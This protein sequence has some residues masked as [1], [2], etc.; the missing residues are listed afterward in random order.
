M[1]RSNYE[2]LTNTDSPLLTIS[3][4]M[5]DGNMHSKFKFPICAAN[6]E[7]WAAHKGN[8]LEW[9]TRWARTTLDVENNRVGLT[10]VGGTKVEFF[11][12]AVH[13]P[14][15]TL[16][17]TRCLHNTLPTSHTNVQCVHWHGREK[18][19][20]SAYLHLTTVAYDILRRHETLFASVVGFYWIIQYARMRLE[21]G[22]VFVNVTGLIYYCFCYNR[23]GSY[24][25]LY[26]VFA[27]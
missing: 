16:S 18:T 13:F 2:G 8:L 25:L 7:N 1:K 3:V 23:T 4:Y 5:T 11:Q 19:V 24:I 12:C 27:N 10:R 17:G 9:D 15:D 20:T 6:S 14:Q 26:T 22:S 21:W